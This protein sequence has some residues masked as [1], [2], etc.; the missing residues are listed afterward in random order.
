MLVTGMGDVPSP[1]P[2]SAMGSHRGGTGSAG[3]GAAT[4]RSA[5]VMH[6]SDPLSAFQHQCGDISVAL[7]VQWVV[8]LCFMF[9]YLIR[10]IFVVWEW[11]HF[12]H[13]SRVSV[14]FVSV[15]LDVYLCTCIPEQLSKDDIDVK[16]FAKAKPLSASSA[17]M[18]LQAKAT[19]GATS[20]GRGSSSSNSHASGTVS[21]KAR[22]IAAGRGKSANSSSSGSG[23]RKR[24]S[25]GTA[26]APAKAPARKR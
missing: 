12:G 10:C 8:C 6:G 24:K 25:S 3:H 14:L 11:Q 1:E 7:P 5:K 9:V 20:R 16:K 21:V 18:V 17:A 19:E 23:S 4:S 26:D 15:T 2:S 13:V 22:G